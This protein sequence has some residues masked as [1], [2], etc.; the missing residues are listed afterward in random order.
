VIV[1]LEGRLS[2]RASLN[3]VIEIQGIGYEVFIPLMTDLPEI[4]GTV[5]LW[6]HTIYRE[7]SQSLYGFNSPKER[8]FFKLVVE[9]VSGIGPKIALAMLSKFKLSD[10]HHFIAT[11][12]AAR[13]ASVPGIGKKTAEKIILELS[14]K[15][16][17]SEKNLVPGNMGSNIC[18]DAILGLITLGYKRQE[19]EAMIQNAISQNPEATPEQ[20]IRRAIVV[21]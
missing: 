18:N 14:G 7:D 20:L 12:D 8:D 4:D 21:R 5:K 3:C 1:T 9:K 6:V 11:R 2:Y 17:H 16:D 13:L 19:A 15:I 10:L